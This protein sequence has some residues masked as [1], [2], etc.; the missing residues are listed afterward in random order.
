MVHRFAPPSPAASTRHW[1]QPGGAPPAEP[2][3]PAAW[4]RR[5][6]W[7]WRRLR[8]MSLPEVIHRVG[9]ALQEGSDRL[10]ARWQGPA[11][12]AAHS[13]NL[14]AL[15]HPAPWLVGAPAALSAQERQA[16][17]TAAQR[18]QAG[19]FIFFGKSH[20]MG[21]PPRWNTC[22][23][24]GREA[25]LRWGMAL[26][27]RDNALV[28]DIK[29]LWEPSRHAELVTLAQAFALTHDLRLARA[30]GALVQSWIAQCPY[31]RGAHWASALEVAI[32]LLHWAAAWQLLGGA[33][34]PLF[35]GPAGQALRRQWLAS[36]WQHQRFVARH[37]SAHSSA[38]NH[39]LGEWL[40]LLV[41]AHT[42]PCWRASP[43]W[44]ARSRA[45]FEAEV[46]R[47]NAPDGVNREQAL[48]YHHEVADM[49]RIAAT[50]LQA[51][52]LSFGP[53][54]A[55]RH[56]AMLDFILA[57]MDA[58][59]HLPALGDSDDAQYLPLVPAS[60]A[61]APV[62]GGL[63]PAPFQSLLAH[64]AIT[65]GRADFKSA[66][67]S[68]DAKTRWLLGPQAPARWE[69]LAAVPPRPARRLFEDGGYA[70]LGT[71]LGEPSE[72]RLVADSGPLG[73][74]SLAAHGHADALAFT[75]SV[76]GRPVLIDP[77]TYSYHTEPAWRDWFRS[78]A[79]HNTVE[80][81]GRNQSEIGGPFLWLRKAH[82][83]LE[84]LEIGPE[85]DVWQA[86]HDGYARGPRPLTHRRRIELDHAL[87]E[88]RVFDSFEGQGPHDAAW[89]WHF[90][91]G[92]VLQP[93]GHGTVTVSQ[94]GAALPAWVIHLPAGLSAQVLSASTQPRGGWVSERLGHK[95]PG[96]TLR[97]SGRIEAHGPNR[98]GLHNGNTNANAN[99]NA[100]ANG[101][102]TATATATATATGIGIGNP[103]AHAG[104]GTTR[105]SSQPLHFLT[106][107]VLSNPAP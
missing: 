4:R 48:W 68:L 31:P 92:W 83:R 20:A 94:P 12:G 75:L 38:N 104:T 84:V 106:R 45:G 54:F 60:T 103:D 18:I 10:Q 14:A 21:F 101:T 9:R 6:G 65:F 70:V 13:A 53:A 98:L 102:G 49:M 100:N 46:L 44:Q 78:T 19:Q 62:H 42:W 28:G 24:T 35:G 59:G 25:P 32:R 56:Q 37:L 15:S 95:A 51:H 26:N 93:G 107:W 90:A 105:A 16:V 91:P 72:L 71:R 29:A 1:P 40:G 55:Q 61:Q 58:G 74:L 5:A 39:R 97:V 43:R 69:A 64:G 96:T 52:G 3:Q 81:D 88:I 11:F 73:Y 36:I 47:Q 77:G 7:L 63:N 87:G 89:H 34:S 33:E 76:H 23:A 57:V 80:I 67:G 99:A 82:A 85:C 50:V 41:A 8:C 27:Y 79:A 66:A 17:L 30:C 22:P 2:G 86:S